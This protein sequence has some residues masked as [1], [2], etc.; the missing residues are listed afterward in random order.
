MTRPHRARG[1][2]PVPDR[3]IGFPSVGPCVRG[4]GRPMPGSRAIGT[5]LR[6]RTARQEDRQE[7]CARARAVLCVPA[8]GADEDRKGSVTWLYLRAARVA[9]FGRRAGRA[10]RKSTRLNSS[11]VAISYAL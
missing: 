11:H 5:S 2:S 3:R 10:D 9:P 6:T 1:E 7:G 8:R 4:V